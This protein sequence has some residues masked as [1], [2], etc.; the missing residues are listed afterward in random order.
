MKRTELEIS[1]DYIISRNN[2]NGVKFDDIWN[3]VNREMNFS[4][5]DED[6]RRADFYTNLC[7]NKGF[8]NLGNNTW[9]IRGNHPYDKVHISMNEIY[10][11]IEEKLEGDFNEEDYDEM[12]TIKKTVF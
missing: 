11:E 3:E 5:G 1:K 9:D 2:Q 4:K 10:S 6:E 7:L 12:A 8:I